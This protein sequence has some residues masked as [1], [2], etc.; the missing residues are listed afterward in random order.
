M[1]SGRPT[2]ISLEKLAAL[3]RPA[4]IPVSGRQHLCEPGAGFGQAWATRSRSGGGVSDGAAAPRPLGYLAAD[5][6]LDTSGDGL[7][8]VAGS[9]RTYTPLDVGVLL[10]SATLSSGTST[11]V[12]G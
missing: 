8:L 10:M 4:G 6:A 9:N 3:L 1:L 12:S 5:A 7:R 11:L 2:T